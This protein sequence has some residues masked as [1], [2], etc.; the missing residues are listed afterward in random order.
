VVS[1]FKVTKLMAF[2]VTATLLIAYVLVHQAI[3]ILR[4]GQITWFFLKNIVRLHEPLRRWSKVRYA[5][6]YLLMAGAIAIIWIKPFVKA[7]S[8]RVLPWMKTANRGSLFVAVFFLVSGFLWL[9]WP[10]KMIRWTIR[11]H[12]GLADEKSI[13]LIGRI[14]GI[15]MIGFA[16]V[17]LANP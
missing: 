8:N 17:V 15:L 1:V 11:T 13:V 14:L 4:T 5:I 16:L 10:K 6:L 2:I 3:Y 12:P 7:N 9:M